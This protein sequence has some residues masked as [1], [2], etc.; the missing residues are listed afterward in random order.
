MIAPTSADVTRLRR[1]RLAVAGLAA[2]VTVAKLV[3]AATTVGSG[4]L[5]LFH[6]FVDGV[7]RYGPIGIYG[8][9]LVPD[10]EYPP[11]YNHAPLSGW[12]LLAVHHLTTHGI[13][14]VAFWIRVPSSLA[15]LAAASIVFE[16]ARTLRSLRQATVAGLLVA[17]SP[18]L[19]IGSGFHGNTD[20]VFVGL[21][22]AAVWLLV[23]RRWPAAAGVAT[24]LALSVKIVPIVVVPAVAV[25]AW[26]QGRRAFAMFCAGA[27]AVLALLWVPVLVRRPVGFVRDVL[28]YT[29][30]LPRRWGWPQF[31]AW[32]GV[33]DGLIEALAGPG[34]WVALA[35][36]TAVPALIVWRRA[37]RLPGAVALALVLFVLLMPAFGIQ[38]LTWP[39]AVAYLLGTA[40]ATGYNAAVSAL[41]VI[42]YGRWCGATW[43][44]QWHRAS[45]DA[46]NPTETVV[47]A[48]GWA[49]L[50]AVAGFG[51]SALRR[52]DQRADRHPVGVP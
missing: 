36:A 30:G 20:S 21:V 16:L 13:G 18:V 10:D 27:G 42:A 26:R 52:P 34:R 51:I 39:L 48:V 49:A 9:D 17:A 40:P 41:Y 46:L 15:D 32:A 37:D 44:W 1:A 3:L 38:Y 31:A 4:D 33:P 8:H 50:A 23:V 7:A 47:A 6:Q 14:S 5:L 2:A 11:L 25:A 28:G 35:V 22:L 12:W 43:P 24:V 19:L 45:V 29:G